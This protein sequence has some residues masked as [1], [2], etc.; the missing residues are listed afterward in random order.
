MDPNGHSRVILYPAMEEA[1]CHSRD[2]RFFQFRKEEK[3][4]EDISPTEN[5]RAGVVNAMMSDA[6]REAEK[7]ERE[8]R[9]A[10][11]AAPAK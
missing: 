11:E 9:P 8:R 4:P 3:R 6:K 10:R 5:R 7:A 1:M 2:F